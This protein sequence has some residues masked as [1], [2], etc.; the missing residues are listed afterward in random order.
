MSQPLG[1]HAVVV[2][3]GIAG[4]VAA[5]ALSAHFDRVTILERDASP[6]KPQSRQ[7]APQDRHLHALLAGGLKAIEQF[8][9]DFERELEEAGAVRLR[10]GLQN[11]VE[12]PGFDSFPL[13]D[14][15][16]DIMSMSR[17]LIEF[18]VRRRVEQASNIALK[19]DCRVSALV[20]SADGASVA[21]VSYDSEAGKAEELAADLVV[22]ASGRGALTLA[23]LERAGFS[24]VEE[25]EIG[26]DQ[27]YS[28]ATFEISPSDAPDWG[29]FLHLP[30]APSSGRGAFASQVEG[31]AWVVSLGGNH[32]DAPPGDADGFMAFVKG[33]RTPTLYDAIKDAKRVGD[34]SRFVLPASI[35]RHFE[36]LERFPRGLIPMG[37]AICRFNPVFGQGMTVAAQEAV[38][39]DRLLSQRS[40]SGDPLDGL[41]PEYFASLQAI[42]AAPWATAE[43]DFVY[44]KTRGR[45]PPEFERRMQFTGALM[46]LAV[47]D[48][49][50]HK[51]LYEVNHLLKPSA[52]LRAPEIAG[53]VSA[54]MAAPA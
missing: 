33:L 49:A 19:S 35:R 38:V 39:L 50:V 30:S 16:F 4:L 31:G 18:L 12:R 29:V 20:A 8:F 46:R 5:K 10:L 54:L 42:L 1:N 27:A 43:S 9:P 40:R 25:T 24:K 48:A 11:K 17:P 44:P 52:L 23:F 51:L 34:I 22:D 41:A 47:E 28:T 32:G 3:A 21:G 53:R 45:R 6:A 37:D 2:G 7:G 14:L 26:I 36:K 15:G 13:R